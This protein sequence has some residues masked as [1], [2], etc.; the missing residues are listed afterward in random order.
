M[1]REL[2][3][4]RRKHGLLTAVV[5]GGFAVALLMMFIPSASATNLVQLQSPAF[6]RTRGVVAE[7]TV[8]VVCK[9]PRPG[10]VGAASTPARA[11]LTV[12][13]LERVGKKTAGGTGKV[14]SK[15]GDFRCDDSSHLVTLF[16]PANA[17]GKPFAKGTAFGQATLK[18]CAGSCRSVTDVRE[19][20]LK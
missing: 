5:S 11:T 3:L 19:I 1:R 15:N 20:K 8:L 16:V 18:V 2:L 12:D 4:G 9:L 14:S 10:T 6:L 17:G 13:L 7:V